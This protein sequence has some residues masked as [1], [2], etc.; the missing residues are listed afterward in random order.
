MSS[1]ILEP[2]QFPIEKL[3]NLS[4]DQ[5]LTA[6]STTPPLIPLTAAVPIDNY[7]LLDPL[8]LKTGSIQPPINGFIPPNEPAPVVNP[9][10]Q[11]TDKLLLVTSANTAQDFTS[12]IPYP[13]NASSGFLPYPMDN[14]AQNYGGTLTPFQP[15]EYI[16][17]NGGTLPPFQPTQYIVGDGGQTTQYVAGNGGNLPPFQPPQ[18]IGG[19]IYP[20]T[21]VN[22]PQLEMQNAQKFPTT[23]QA[24]VVEFYAQLQLLHEFF[25]I[26]GIRYWLTGGSLLGQ[27]R[28]RRFLRWGDNNAIG[29]RVVDGPMIF[30][31][32]RAFLKMRNPV[33]EIWNS[34]H[35]LKLIN[36]KIK[37]VATDIYYYMLKDQ[38]CVLASE[39]SRKQWP[40][41]NFVAQDLYTLQAVK[42]GDFVVIIPQNPASYL[43]SQYGND[44]MKV[45]R[46]N[47]YDHF[48]NAGR[49]SVF[50]VPFIN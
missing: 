3:Q 40:R 50:K 2:A 9:V 12:V 39:R 19:N 44:F 20:T 47:S 33:Y 29:V 34:V 27:Y 21:L 10:L 26:S 17:N 14:G 11:V 42:F 41:D 32:L 31:K 25:E 45:A 18:Y 1:T 35:G 8:L 30:D 15:T 23:P 16:V 6:I 13:T 48:A 24:H 28:E 36:K 43:S 7:P 4:G 22:P 46:L 5:T 49:P 38:M 37:G